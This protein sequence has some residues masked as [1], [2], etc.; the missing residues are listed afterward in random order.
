MALVVL[1]MLA[2]VLPASGGGQ[3]AVFRT[4]VFAVLVALL[5]TSTFACLVRRRLSVRSIGFHLTH[6]SVLV[7][8]A[9]ALV[10]VVFEKK[11]DLRLG[12]HED[13]S[14][15]GV[16]LHDGTIVEL[17]FRLALKDFRVDKY[18]PSLQL[19][20]HGEVV[21]EHRSAEGREIPVPG[22][23][24]TVERVIPHAAIAGVTLDGTPELSIGGESGMRIVMDGDHPEEVELPGG[25]ILRITRVYNNLPTMQMGQRFRETEFPSR[26][27]LIMRVIVSN[28]MAIVSLPAGGDA[29]LLSASDAEIE[30]EIPELYYAF[31]PVESME[32]VASRDPEAPPA[33]EIEE[34]DGERSFLVEDGGRFSAALLSDDY[35]LSL[36]PSTDRRYEADLVITRDGKQQERTLVINQPLDVAGWRIYL[37]SYDAQARQ[38]ITITLRRDPGDRIVVAGILGLMIGTATIF[39]VRKRKTA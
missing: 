21:S 17:G 8:M 28:R 25:G 35:A 22:G 37:N 38:H 14:V 7:I 2:G 36:G 10:G 13:S 5:G 11:L 16:R 31:P 30:Q 24:V 27:G 12:L 18:L 6:F 3:D 33:I 19:R 20:R 29:T 1:L 39:Y 4:P 34:P 15:E 26:P 9:G 23:H 32:V